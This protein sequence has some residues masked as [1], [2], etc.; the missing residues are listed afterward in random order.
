MFKELCRKIEDIKKK[1]LALLEMKNI[2]DGTNSRLDIA[3][4]KIMELENV[5]IERIQNEMLRKKRI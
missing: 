3:E 5:A 2:L 1:D 4:E